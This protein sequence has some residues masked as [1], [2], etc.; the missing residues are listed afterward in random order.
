MMT[1]VV[2]PSDHGLTVLARGFPQKRWVATAFGHVGRTGRPSPVDGTVACSS[3][4]AR[5]REGTMRRNRTPICV[6]AAFERFRS[7]RVHQEDPDLA[8]VVTGPRAH[9]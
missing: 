6:L 9:E 7:L 4:N 1:D 3:R 5:T 8:T 2:R